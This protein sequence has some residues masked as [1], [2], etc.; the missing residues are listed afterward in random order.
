M[1]H[2]YRTHHAHE[3]NKELIGQTVTLNGWVQ[4]QRNLGGVIFIDLRDRSGVVQVVVN[5]D[6]SPE[7]AEIAEQVRSEYVLSITG[8]VVARS[9]E[10]VNPK[11]ATGDIEVISKEI[12]VFNEAK[13]PPFLIQDRVEVDEAIRLKYRYLDLRR[14][15]MQQTMLIRHRAMQLVRRYLDQYGFIEVET[16]MLTKSTPEGARD[17]L[18]P[19]RVHKGSFYALPQSPQLFKQLLMVAG[20][21]RY[22][23]FARCFRDEDLRSDRQP[24]FTQIDIE[25]SFLPLETF[26][27]MME[28]MAALLLKEIIDVE[29]PTPFQ[30]MSYQ[31]AMDRYGSDKPDL[32]FGMELINLSETLKE[33][34]FKVFASTIASGGQV[35]A[36]NVKG[37]AHWSR[38]EID[39]WGK[40]AEKLGAKG[41]AW[42]ALKEE[43]VKGSVA[44]FL[45]EAEITSI[46]Q[47]AQAETGDLLF[48][49]ADRPAVVADV[50]G[51]LRVRLGQQ[52]KLINENEYRFVWITEFPLLEYSEEDGRFYAKHHPF[53]SPMEEDLPL[54]KTNPEQVRAVA[55]DMVLN[56]YEVAGGSRRI[57]RREVQ[58]LMFHALGITP[59]E[60]KEKFGFLL[61]AFEYG[62][63][64]H[65]GIAFG[66]DRLVM[67]LAG[68]TNLR[69][70]IPFPKTA[71]A[72]C[73]MTQAPS[74][75]D[76]K[77]LEELNIE[78]RKDKRKEN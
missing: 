9:P 67:L 52:L 6:S 12:D 3:C 35:K 8:K 31:E 73:L 26:L 36:L 59:E 62:A 47:A 1:G 77:Q 33:T 25:A 18:V 78:L 56:G 45:S 38:K 37:C 63:P 15:K 41:L 51:G 39:Q 49:V 5:P 64:P 75:V 10:T 22:F 72:S 53:T 17:Y 68:R 60:A 40:E 66:F 76:E 55:Y 13:T 19:S 4:K 74:T 28:E 2:G 44:K 7:L 16:P 34:S 11:M 42:I 27:T 69:E 29:V 20:M 61:E 50:L 24:E 70:C 14:P 54:M 48:F 32:R 57:H 43:G 30:R 46:C 21:E 65:G 23:Q 71:S 58:E